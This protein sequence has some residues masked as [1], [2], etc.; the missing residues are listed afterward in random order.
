MQIVAAQKEEFGSLLLLWEESVRQT[1]DFLQAAD[2]EFLK[3]KVLDYFE[4]VALFVAKRDDKTL[5]FIG[6]ND[7]KIEMLFVSIDEFGRGV[8]RS[9][10]QF[11]FERFGVNL[12]DV[13]EQNPNARAFYKRLGFEVYD[14]DEFDS[15]GNAF[16][17]LHMKLAPLRSHSGS[18]ARR[19]KAKT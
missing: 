7:K 1:H 13:N 18:Q 2:I 10:V 4:E 5:G 15:F 19:Q 9:L 3:P 6:I 8:G 12:V 11:A 17:I 14:R 16:P